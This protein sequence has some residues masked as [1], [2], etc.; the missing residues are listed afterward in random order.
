MH[1]KQAEN[2][3]KTRTVDPSRPVAG[4]FGIS[5]QPTRVV[6]AMEGARTADGAISHRL[7]FYQNGFVEYAKRIVHISKGLSV[8]LD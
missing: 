7:A 8:I 1:R 4:P 5:Q 3:A 2:P 6:R